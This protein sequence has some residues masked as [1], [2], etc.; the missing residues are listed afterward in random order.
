[1]TERAKIICLMG[2]TGA[3][4]TDLAIALH[5]QLNCDVISVDSA[6]I[7]HGMDIGTAKPDA[8]T[9]AAC[10]HRLID[11]CDP[12][13]V[14]SAAQF[15]MD[16]L[17]E[18]DDIIVAGA[19]PLL[20]GGTMLYFRALQQGLSQLPAADQNVRAAISARAERVGWQALHAELMRTDPKAAVRIDA[21]DPQRI[22]RALE[23]YQITGQPL[24]TLWD[25]DKRVSFPYDV[26]NIA[27]APTQ[28]TQLHARIAKRF[29][30]ML[31]DGLIDEVRRLYARDDLNAE[32]PAL[33]AVGYR[34]VWQYLA[35]EYD[36]EQMRERAI[37]ATRQLAKRQLTWLRHWP[38]LAW[39]V[40]EDPKLI[41]N[42]LHSV[43]GFLRSDA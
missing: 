3:G 42:V 34:Q 33:R 17:R 21:N 4:K 24:S 16:A 7:Y 13:Q 37:A 36:Y 25:T 6:M 8:Q 38:E 5:E 39:F 31:D 1:M 2:P 28:R 20:V 32:L 19:T 35:G 11:L 30:Q 15:R 40:S 41:A 18:I 9:L 14:Y 29:Q 27:V 12:S 10:P 26:L 22:Q 43:R 23:V